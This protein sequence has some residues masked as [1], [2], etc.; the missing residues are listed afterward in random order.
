MLLVCLQSGMRTMPHTT[1]IEG[2]KYTLVIAS[3]E[4]KII[5]IYTLVIPSVSVFFSKMPR[6]Q[7]S[8]YLLPRWHPAS[9]L[10]M[11]YH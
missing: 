2:E 11:E 4:G 5:Y 6:C 8:E 3:I 7:I 9:S 1:S 10:I